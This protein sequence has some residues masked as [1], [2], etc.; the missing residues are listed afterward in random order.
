MDLDRI[1]SQLIRMDCLNI[2]DG[3]AH[4]G[5]SKEVYAD[6]LRVFCR[7][8]ENKCSDIKKSLQNEDWKNYSAAMH[9]VKGGLAGIGVLELPEKVSELEDASRKEDYRFCKQNSSKVLKKLIQFI[10]ILK[11]SALFAEEKK[12]REQV[13]IKYM[14]EK[15]SELYM[16]CSSGSSERADSLAH[17][18]KSKTYGEK[19]DGFINVICAHVENLDYHLALQILSEQPYIK[20][21]PHT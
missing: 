5:C 1:F 14:Q 15:L 17:E 4:V 16:Y 2:W 9:A 20:S 19:A 21:H 18:L 3:L 13:S 10:D 11:S 6:T 7:D 12:E 8:L